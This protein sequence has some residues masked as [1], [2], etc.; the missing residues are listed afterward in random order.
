M[1]PPPP[2]RS[3]P[4]NGV[5]PCRLTVITRQP[6]ASPGS[7]AATDPFAPSGRSKGAVLVHH[8]TTNTLRCR[9]S[10]ANSAPRP[11]PTSVPGASAVPCCAAIGSQALFGNSQ[12]TPARPNASRPPMAA[13][14]IHF[15]PDRHYDR[16]PATT[17]RAVSRDTPPVPQNLAT[18]DTDPT[19]RL[20]RCRDQIRMTFQTRAGITQTDSMGFWSA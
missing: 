16:P 12:G 4:L 19:A 13:I 1:A 5:R 6:P 18:P 20:R 14:I 15:T 2:P 3:D 11:P 8:R 17:E 9:R 10:S 7:A